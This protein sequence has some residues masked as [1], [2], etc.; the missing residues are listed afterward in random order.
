MQPPPIG[1][2]GREG[3]RGVGKSLHHAKNMGPHI[4]NIHLQ[5]ANVKWKIKWNV[6]HVTKLPEVDM[7]AIKQK[8]S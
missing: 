4:V 5:K 8:M 6:E 3:G 7:S 2:K 1:R